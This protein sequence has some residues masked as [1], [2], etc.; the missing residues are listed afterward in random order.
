MVLLLSNNRVQFHSIFTPCVLASVITSFGVNTDEIPLV[1]Y[2]EYI[3][4]FH[5]PGVRIE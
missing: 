3:V 2:N 1:E 4:N 5:S